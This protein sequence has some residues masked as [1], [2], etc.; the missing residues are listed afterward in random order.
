MEEVHV[1][2]RYYHWSEREI[3]D[4]ASSKRQRYLALVARDLAALSE[5]SEV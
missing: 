3:L 5:R 4:L 2:A 1:L